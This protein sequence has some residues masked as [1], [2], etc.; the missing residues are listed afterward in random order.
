M[1][2]Q[3]DNAINCNPNK[4]KKDLYYLHTLIAFAITAIFWIIPPFEPITALGMRCVGTFLSMIYL[5][6][7]VDVMWPCLYGL[8]MFGLAG[9]AGEGYAGMKAVWLNAVGIDTVMITLFAMVLFGAVSEVGDTEYIAKW[10]LTK[11]IF[12][13]RP[14]VFLAIF[15]ACCFVLSALV[16]PITELII[17]WPI[18]LG[19]MKTLGIERCDKIW[20][21]FFVGMFLVSTLAQPFFPFMGAQLIPIS[22]FA[23]MTEAMGNPMD[24]PIV[25][26]ML[27]DLIM[28][29]LIMA[30]YLLLLKFV[31]R[32]DVSKLKAV[33]P[34]QIEVQMLLPPMN[35]QQ[36]AYLYMIPC[37]LIMLLIPNFIK[38]NPISD[39]LSTMGT[40]GVTVFWVLVFVIVKWNGKPL[41]DFK[42]VAYKQMNWGIF[43]MIA[44]AVYGANTLANPA[45][46]VV[47]FL[48]KVLQPVLGGRPEWLFVL[49]MF[50]VALVITNFA[51]N[52]AMAVTL[53]PVALA[54]CQQLNIDPIPVAIG[55]VLMVFVAMLTPSAS[56]HGSMMHARKDIY[57]T[58]EILKIGLP[59]CIITLLLY[60]FVGYPLC[61]FLL[62]VIGA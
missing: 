60:S 4:K 40:L 30:V 7:F 35:F 50:T 51:N 38:G 22:A 32:V 36:K 10:F 37:Y 9:Y 43:F 1:S 2:N 33:N 44:A 14:Y 56:P 46:G 3:Q 45:T 52:A 34:E 29:T 59:M 17:L 13:G 12:A 47:D 11:K 5:W 19:L 20:P 16:S 8:F 18:A 41:L 23:A 6:T 53:L 25:S 55:I 15:Y 62:A 48:V 28:T 57:S 21:Y 24:V 61:K 26:Y 42:E 54:F 27:L 31:I 49:L 39:L 58:Q